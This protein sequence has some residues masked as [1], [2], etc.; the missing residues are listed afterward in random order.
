MHKHKQYV[1]S[2]SGQLLLQ[3]CTR[4]RLL[5]YVTFG[6]DGVNKAHAFLLV[7]YSGLAGAANREQA[8][9][10]HEWPGIQKLNY[11]V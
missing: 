1:D 5:A 9:N 2:Y 4:T 10:R 7:A 6:K 11:H 3:D 8:P